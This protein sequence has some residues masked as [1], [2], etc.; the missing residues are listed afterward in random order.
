MPRAFTLAACSCI[1]TTAKGYRARGREGSLFAACHLLVFIQALGFAL[2]TPVRLPAGIVGA[3]M[4]SAPS[5]LL[6]SPAGGSAVAAPV[7]S[8]R[9]KVRYPKCS[10]CRC[11]TA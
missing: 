6:V 1:S 3:T 4:A 9:K 10:K 5:F 7:A 11:L 2:A 8:A